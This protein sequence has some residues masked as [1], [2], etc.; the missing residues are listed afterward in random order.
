MART[1]ALWWL[2]IVLH[3]MGC[4]RPS[5]LGYGEHPGEQKVEFNDCLTRM[6]KSWDWPNGKLIISI[7]FSY[8]P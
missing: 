2:R 8:I 6:L 7:F 5:N 1:V 3:L 4:Q